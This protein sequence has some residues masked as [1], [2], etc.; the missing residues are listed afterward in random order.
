MTTAIEYEAVQLRAGRYAVRPVGC[1]G[2]CGWHA[3]GKP[4][5]VQYITALGE[6]AALRKAAAERMQGA[7][8]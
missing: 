7:R 8:S 3:N 4:W 1:L 5:Q 6:Y 2:T